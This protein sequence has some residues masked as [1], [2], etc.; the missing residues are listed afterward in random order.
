M[1]FSWLILAFNAKACKI[2][3]TETVQCAAFSCLFSLY[4]TLTEYMESLRKIKLETINDAK[5]NMHTN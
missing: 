5:N 3:P 2:C 1:F 4:F